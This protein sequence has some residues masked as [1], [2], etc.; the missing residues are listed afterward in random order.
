M[1]IEA[2]VIPVAFKHIYNHITY[3]YVSLS[4]KDTIM[5][6]VTTS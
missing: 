1:H 5:S 2:K 4:Y 3:D 6:T